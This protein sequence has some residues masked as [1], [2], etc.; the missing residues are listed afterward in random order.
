[1][2]PWPPAGELTELLYSAV[3]PR[4]RCGTALLA[5]DQADQG[6]QNTTDDRAE[7]QRDERDTGHQEHDMTAL[8]PPPLVWP[9]AHHDSLECRN[10]GHIIAHGGQRRCE[11]RSD[12]PQCLGP[13]ARG[14]EL[15]RDPG[16]DPAVSACVAQDGSLGPVVAGGI[17]ICVVGGLAIVGGVVHRL[18]D[19]PLRGPR[20]QSLTIIDNN[21]T[22]HYLYSPGQ[23]PSLS[24]GREHRWW[25]AGPTEK[26]PHG[27]EQ[28]DQ[29]QDL[30][31]SRSHQRGKTGGDQCQRGRVA[32][33]CR[34]RVPTHRCSRRHAEGLPEPSRCHVCDHGDR[35]GHQAGA[36]PPHAP[37][38]TD[39]FPPPGLLWAVSASETTRTNEIRR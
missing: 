4:F 38:T 21:R 19:V 37:L 14:P 20:Q 6:Q 23:A 28:K 36:Q 16:T 25:H 22:G 17:R 27:D 10:A 12:H 8:G 32:E 9:R 34:R 1:M 24:T 11:L 29:P 39:R 13:A 33:R 7:E 5:E 3:G 15:G 30:H 2:N 18:P 31:T 35:R 26:T